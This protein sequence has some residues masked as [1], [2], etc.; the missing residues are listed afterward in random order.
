MALDNKLI[1]IAG[2]SNTKYYYYIYPLNSET[3]DETNK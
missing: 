3:T 1:S 2:L